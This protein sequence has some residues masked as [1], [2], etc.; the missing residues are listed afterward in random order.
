M[1]LGNYPAST[2]GVRVSRP[3]APDVGP[4]PYYPSAQMFE[5]EESSDLV[6]YWRLLVRNRAIL[7]LAAGIGAVVGLLATLPQTPMY[8]ASTNIEIQPPNQ[9]FMNQRQMDPMQ[10][11]YSSD[12]FLETQAALLGSRGLVTRVIDKLE[13]TTNSGALVHESWVDGLRRT[14]TGAEE[15]TP[16]QNQLASA[17]LNSLRVKTKQGTQI[18]EVSFDSADPMFAANFVN[19]MADEFIEQSIESRWEQSQRTGDWLS[20]QMEQVKIKLEKSEDELQQYA[21]SA[22][23]MFM[24]DEGSVDESK[25]RGM[26]DE[27]LQAT[28]ER[29]K[30]QSRYELA[31]SSPPESLG[32]SLDDSGLRGYQNKLADLR[33]QLAEYRTLFTDKHHKVRLTEAQITEVEETAERLRK[34]ILQRVRN[35]FEASKRREELLRGDYNRQSTHVSDLSEKSIRYSILKRE[36]ETNRQV[37]DSM[38]QRVKESGIAAA[39]RASNI[40]VVDVAYPPSAPFRPSK[41]MNAGIGMAGALFLG[42]A[43]I[44]MRERS[45]RTFRQ[46]G[47]APAVLGV[48]ELGTIPSSQVSNGIA[49]SV[50]KSL[51]GKPLAPKL[52]KK[53]SLPAILPPASAGDAK[54]KLELITHRRPQSILSESFRSTATSLLVWESLG[55]LPR[56][57]ALTSPDPG[58]G[59][60]TVSCNLATSFAIAGKRVLLVDGDLRRPRVHD[61]FRIPNVV[62]LGTLLGSRAPNWETIDKMECIFQTEVPGLH[63]MPAGALRGDITTL[64]FSSRCSELFAVLRSSYDMVMIDCPPMLHLA[65]ARILGLVAEGVIVV[66]RA[67]KTTREEATVA[68]ER[69]R[70][71]GI[72]VLG[73]IL[74]DW[75][76]RNS[77]TSSYTHQN[78]YN[79]Y[80]SYYRQSEKP[81]TENA[82]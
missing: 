24:R 49:A 77:R 59:K 27:L 65:D 31:Q 46:P 62:G 6:T 30:L 38:L 20:R 34:N 63:V 29:V 39:L 2:G 43:F 82:S 72:Q 10:S 28:A 12:T 53:G 70:R 48:Q 50:H 76:P 80:S 54:E 7:L 11:T 81:R 42:V 16:D 71:D 5:P 74:N 17:A 58:D 26:Q 23:L 67:G 69:L 57:I 21:R 45:D 13:L 64:L 8:R 79:K 3:V 75:N 18:V 4:A 66:L 52:L 15:T 47:E 41:V 25:L 35:D 51:D 60:T 56:V 9:D 19:K 44:F 40:R 32:D 68:I 1:P 14:V 78:Y 33:R 22:G 37:Y 55:E 73:T 61:V 36:V